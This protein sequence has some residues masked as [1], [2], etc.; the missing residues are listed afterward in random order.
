MKHWPG[1]ISSWNLTKT[2]LGVVPALTTI[3]WE[4]TG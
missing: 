1:Q 3:M 4:D 2:P